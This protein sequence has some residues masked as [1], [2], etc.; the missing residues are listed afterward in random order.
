MYENIDDP[1]FLKEN[2]VEALIALK[3]QDHATLDRLAVRKYI[4]RT[5]LANPDARIMKTIPKELRDIF[6]PW[7]LEQYGPFRWRVTNGLVYYTVET[8]PEAEGILEW[9]QNG[10]LANPSAET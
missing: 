9:K 10:E 4:E 8:K 6:H 5:E 3:N 2:L 7:R 1:R